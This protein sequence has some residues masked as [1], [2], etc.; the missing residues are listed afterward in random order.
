MRGTVH[1]IWGCDLH[2][3]AHGGE[4]G[5]YHDDPQDFDGGKREDRDATRVFE[6]KADQECAGL[7]DVL[8]VSDRAVVKVTSAKR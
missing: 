3:Q 7:R 5:C 1:D 6:D 8:R 4:P 2:S